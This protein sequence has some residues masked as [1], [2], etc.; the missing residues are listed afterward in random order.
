M[1]FQVTQAFTDRVPELASLTGR[2]FADDPNATWSLGD[3]A[4]ESQVVQWFRAEQMLA[5][6][7]GF[8]WEAGRGLGAAL[9]FPPG[10]E[11]LYLQ[12]DQEARRAAAS[13][14]DDEGVRSESYLDWIAEQ[15][16]PEPHWLLDHIAVRSDQR[17][18]GIG[19]AL[20][21]VGLSGARSGMVPAFLET[22]RPENVPIY[23]HIGFRVT[24]HDDAPSNGPHVW[25]MRFEP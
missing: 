22:A 15:L 24:L 23:E 19:R 25:F 1:T 5:A 13:L 9:W 18:K 10:N 2:A 12:I 8:L 16:P 20:I 7:H 21:E 11:E 3:G 14:S 17:G 6:H 4:A